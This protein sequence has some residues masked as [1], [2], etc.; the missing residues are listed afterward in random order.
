MKFSACLI[1]V[2]RG[3][4]VCEEDLAWALREG[5]IAGA[6]LDVME[7]EPPQKDNPLLALDNV[8]LTPH[9]AWYSEKS[10]QR[11]QAAAAREVARVL[12]GREPENCV[13][14]DYLASQSST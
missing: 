14:Q 4:L 9:A 13:N 7:Q 12:S 11:L 8:I 10:Q 2:A 3:G 5:Q 1:N 6:A